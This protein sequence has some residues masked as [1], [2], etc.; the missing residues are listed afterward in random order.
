MIKQIKVGFMFQGIDNPSPLDTSVTYGWGKRFEDTGELREAARLQVH[1]VESPRVKPYSLRWSWINPRTGTLKHLYDLET[2][3]DLRGSRV[4]DTLDVI[5]F[6]GFGSARFVANNIDGIIKRLEYLKKKGVPCVNNTESVLA[7]GFEDKD[8]L[9]ELQ[10]QGISVPKSTVAKTVEEVKEAEGTLGDIVTKPMRGHGGFGIERFPGGNLSGVEEVLRTQGRIL[11]QK[12]IP[13][14]VQGE[15]SVYL[16][17]GEPRYAVRKRPQIGGFL[18]NSL[19]ATVEAIE[20]TREEIALAKAV[21]KA[22]GVQPSLMRADMVGVRDE[23]VLMEYTQEA[24]GMNAR[25]TGM[26]EQ[27]WNW[28]VDLFIQEA[29]K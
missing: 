13:E 21:P 7:L 12:F 10:R 18:C 17:S 19:G 15:R 29:E 27:I 16:F 20:P 25:Y 24:I 4:E 8:Y 22:L 11:V 26:E 6:R 9:L 1:L 3:E 5:Y 2:G 23:P 14:V 28:L